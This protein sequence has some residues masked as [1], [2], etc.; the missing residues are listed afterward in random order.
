[1]PEL[2]L[3]YRAGAFFARVQCPDVLLGMQTIEEVSD[4]YG[5]EEQKQTI[6]ISL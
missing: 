4:V 1:M 5:Y 3:Q 6:K 2:M